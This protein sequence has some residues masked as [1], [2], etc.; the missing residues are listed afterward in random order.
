MM[1]NFM[2]TLIVY[3]ELAKAEICI[4]RIQAGDQDGCQIFANDKVIALFCASFHLIKSAE[5]P[6]KLFYKKYRIYMYN[7]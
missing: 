5:I 2:S 7:T 3:C 1:A 4:H 6:M